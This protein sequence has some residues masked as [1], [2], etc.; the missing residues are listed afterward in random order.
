ML[1]AKIAGPQAW[2]ALM[3][4]KAA[5]WESDI[6][7]FSQDVA[8]VS[9]EPKFRLGPEDVFFCI[10]SCFARNIEEH[11]IYAGHKVLSRRVICPVEEWALRPNGF[12]NKFTTMSMLNELEWTLEPPRVDE[13]CSRKPRRAGKISNSR[14]AFRRRRSIER[15]NGAAI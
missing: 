2:T 7:R 6:A 1:G 15:S 10:G 5:N 8:L 3:K 11:L 12:V 13:T 9:H 4:S 14:L